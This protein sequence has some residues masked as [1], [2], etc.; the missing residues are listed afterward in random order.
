[1]TF[2]L[3]SA[4]PTH[5]PLPPCPWH[6][7]ARGQLVPTVLH[8]GG[9]VVLEAFRVDAGVRENG[10]SARTGA[11]DHLKTRDRGVESGQKLGKHCVYPTSTAPHGEKCP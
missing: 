4:P 9:P 10:P 7:G 8:T 5:G 6:R 1:M 3:W 11:Q 2:S